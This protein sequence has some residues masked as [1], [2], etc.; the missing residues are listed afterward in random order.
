MATCQSGEYSSDEEDPM[1]V[2]AP[3]KPF[4]RLMESVRSTLPDDVYRPSDDT[5][6]ILKTFCDDAVE[7]Q[8]RK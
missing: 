6:V 5:F 2:T 4:V 7:L 1:P 3:P 8:A